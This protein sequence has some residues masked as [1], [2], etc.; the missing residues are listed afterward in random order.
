[1]QQIQIAS[2]TLTKRSVGRPKGALSQRVKEARQLAAELGDP[3]SFLLRVV[4]NR[5]AP[6]DSRIRAAQA[7]CIHIHPKLAVSHVT[8]E[9]DHSIE[10]RKIQQIAV[11][12]A[13]HDMIE[14]LVLRMAQ[15]TPEQAHDAMFTEPAALLPEPASEPEADEPDNDAEDVQLFA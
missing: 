9:V 2:T 11:D 12:P 7:A 8:K 14:T 1:M 13:I 4:R 15:V 6:L 3:L 10:F 5:K